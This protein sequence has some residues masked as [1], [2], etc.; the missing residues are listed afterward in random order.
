MEHSS[1]LG[2]SYAVEKRRIAMPKLNVND[3]QIYYEVHGE[4][5][6]LVMIMGLGANLDWWDPRMVQELSKRFMTVLFDNRGA[7][8]TDVSDRNYTIRLLA[9]DTAALMNGLGISRAHVLGISMG[10]M[11]AQ[12]LALNYPQ[13]VEKLVLCSTFCGGEKSVL[14]SGDVMGTLTADRG[15]M[16]HEEVVKMVIPV[17][18]T[19]DFVKKNPELVELLMQRIL[20]SPISVEPYRRQLSAVLEF[21]TH[22][23]LPQIKAPTLILCGRKDILV[24]PGNGPIL[25]EAIPNSRLVYLE[26][27]AHALAEDMDEVINL[28]TGFLG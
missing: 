10:G 17:I 27:S 7:G 13:K 24:P 18:L 23:R 8:R 3:I 28:V 5:I 26:R 1:F 25:A 9:D 2:K 15:T 19:E 21:N 20:K 22:A 12:E 6:P 16:S 11:I 4:G 14:P